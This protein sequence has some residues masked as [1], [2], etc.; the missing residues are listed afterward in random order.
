MLATGTLSREGK[1][2]R[3]G[4]LRVR[5]TR[6][7]ELAMERVANVGREESKLRALECTDASSLRVRTASVATRAFSFR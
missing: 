7:P 6:S 4:Y 5:I 3:G 1:Y 2:L